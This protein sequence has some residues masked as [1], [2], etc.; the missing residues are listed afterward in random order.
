MKH[1]RP[2]KKKLHE[3]EDLDVVTDTEIQKEENLFQRQYRKIRSLIKPKRVN[4]KNVKTK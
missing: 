2:N 1:V 4:P 3:Y